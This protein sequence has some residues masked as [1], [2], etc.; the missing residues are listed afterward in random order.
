MG[1]AVRRRAVFVALLVAA[2]LWP[3]AGQAPVAAVPRPPADPEADRVETLA[4]TTVV[5]FQSTGWKYLQVAQGGGPSDFHDPAFDDS[6]WS[7]GQAAF[8]SNGGCSVQSTTNTAW[9]GAVERI[10]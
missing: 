1:V 8:G 10:S 4:P 2:L 7:T 6:G 5:G 9:S 3:L